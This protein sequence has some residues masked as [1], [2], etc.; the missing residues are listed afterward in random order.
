MNSQRFL[1]PLYWVGAQRVAEDFP[2]LDHALDEP[3]GLLAIGGDLRCETLLKAYRRGI[4]PWYSPG[5]PILWWSPEPR[6]V[7]PPTQVHVSRSLAKHMAKGGFELCCDRDFA[8]VID[9][10]AAPRDADSGTWITAAMRSAY[11][12]LHAAGHAHAIEYRIDG[13][14]CGGLYGVA[15]G[16]VFF[17]ESMFSLE[18]DASKVVLVS[19]CRWLCAWGYELLDCQIPS[20]HLTSLGVRAMPRGEF[21][22][23]LSALIDRA[24]LAHAWRVLD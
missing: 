3:N 11:L 10:C 6:A 20:A 15:I 16:R 13:R 19:L 5:Q 1:E 23:R 22:H 24:P 21:A 14:L 4:F 7:L 18:R 2:P 9:A 8:A 12:A 17:G